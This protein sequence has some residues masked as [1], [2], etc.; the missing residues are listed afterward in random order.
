MRKLYNG[1]SEAFFPPMHCHK[2]SLNTDD[3][4]SSEKLSFSVYTSTFVQDKPDVKHVSDLASAH[5]V[6]P[7][8]K[9]RS[10]TIISQHQL[11]GPPSI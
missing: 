10:A 7:E 4:Q 5:I 6:S 11:R 1:E 3:F 2:V 9:C 8:P